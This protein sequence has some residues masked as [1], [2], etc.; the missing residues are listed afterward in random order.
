MT[1]NPRGIERS[2]SEGI[3]MSPGAVSY[4]SSWLY[5]GCMVLVTLFFLLADWGKKEEGHQRDERNCCYGVYYTSDTILGAMTQII[6]IILSSNPGG[7][8]FPFYT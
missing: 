5:C 3:A 6:L 4:H 8:L 7:V 2:H 1:R